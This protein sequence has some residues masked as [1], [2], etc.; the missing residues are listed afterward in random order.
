MTLLV[1]LL[2]MIVLN[3]MAVLNALNHHHH[4]HNAI[5]VINQVVA[6][7]ACQNYAH[8]KRFRKI[9]IQNIITLLQN[10]NKIGLS[11]VVK[12]LLHGYEYACKVV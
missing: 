4:Q 9:I 5:T 3:V 7:F 6:K 2:A 11:R 1:V 8:P 10:N 12:Y